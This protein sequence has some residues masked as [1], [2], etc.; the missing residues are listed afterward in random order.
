M[1]EKELWKT[2]YEFFDISGKFDFV[3]SSIKL[4][5]FCSRFYGRIASKPN[6]HNSETLKA[7]KENALGLQKISVE[8][9][10]MEMRRILVG[11]HAPHLVELMVELGVAKHIGKQACTVIM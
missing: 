10:W 7:I 11:N 8:R 4:A 6:C 3:W 9:V 5:V 1:L 2:T